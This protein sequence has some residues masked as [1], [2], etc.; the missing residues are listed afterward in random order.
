ML[1]A[2]ARLVLRNLWQFSGQDTRSIELILYIFSVALYTIRTLSLPISNVIGIAGVLLPVAN[3]AG[4][5]GIR[6][7]QRWSN[8]SARRNEILSGSTILIFLLL[9]IYETA[10]A[11]LSLTH[12]APAGNLTCA[13]NRNWERLFRSKDQV[14]IRRIQDAHQCCGLHSIKD[15]AWPFQDRNHE[16]DACATTFNRTKACF[17]S[18]RRD[19]QIA[20]GLLL[21]VA[22]VGFLLQ[23]SGYT[24]RILLGGK[25]CSI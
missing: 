13:L 20:A 10:I 17:G 7:L 22:I 8:G 14:R 1:L 24:V 6:S 16:V 5:Q 12:M 23:V 15:K 4:L 19:E 2:I 3:A 25:A 11:T 18:W 21:V 9:T